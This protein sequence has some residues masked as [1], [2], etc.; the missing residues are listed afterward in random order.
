[1]IGL[2]S[3]TQ[4]NCSHLHC[5]QTYLIVLLLALKLNH[6]ATFTDTTTPCGDAVDGFSRQF[7]VVTA[8][9][10]ITAILQHRCLWGFMGVHGRQSTKTSGQH[11]PRRILAKASQH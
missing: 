11:I 3:L 5:N 2:T 9:A 4:G 8:P 6:T 10:S 1:M 7:S